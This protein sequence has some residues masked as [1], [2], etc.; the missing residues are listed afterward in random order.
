MAKYKV[1]LVEEERDELNALV[2]TGKAAARKLN[3]ARI[4]LLSDE[5]PGGPGK[6]DGE[7][8]NALDTGKR[9]IERVRKRFVE[10]GIEQAIDPRP[11]PKRPSK[12]KIKGEIE[13][14][15]IELACSAPPEGRGRWTLQL[16][17]DQLVVLTS[18]ES[19]S[20]E[21]VRKALK[22]RTSTLQP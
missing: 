15:L 3:H 19:V 2:K 20:D 22:K 17:A 6:T 10:E 1:T 11:R 13:E 5:G 12:V 8:A 16:L 9:T 4:L 7:I 14:Q 18:L 21:T